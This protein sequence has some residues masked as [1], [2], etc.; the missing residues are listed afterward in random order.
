MSFG[1]PATDPLVISVGASTHFRSYV[2]TNTD[3]ASLRH[4]GLAE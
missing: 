2:Q 3:A 1:S 4:D